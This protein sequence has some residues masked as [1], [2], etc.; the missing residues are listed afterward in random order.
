MTTDGEGQMG[1][2]GEPS[3]VVDPGVVG[4]STGGGSMADLERGYLPCG[5]EYDSAMDGDVMTP[6]GS[7]DDT[8]GFLDRPQGWE[9]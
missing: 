7:L 3:L 6:P 1:E 8:T 9:R 2:G 4:G 5:P